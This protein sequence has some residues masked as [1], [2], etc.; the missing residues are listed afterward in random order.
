[1]RALVINPSFTLHTAVLDRYFHEVDRFELLT[2]DEEILLGEKIRAGDKSALDKLVKANLRFVISVAKK[3]Q[4][5]GMSLADLIAEGNIGLMT[6]AQRFDPSKGF[7]FISFAVWW[8]RQAIMH[9]ITQKQRMVRLPGNQVNTILSINQ[10]SMALEQMLERIPSVEQ[11]AEYTGLSSA[12]VLEGIGN[13]GWTLSLDKEPEREQGASLMELL[14][15]PN[16]LAP[17]QVLLDASV[18]EEL[19]E[20][21]EG[22]PERE[23]LILEHLYGLGGKVLLEAEDIARMLGLS[24]ERVRQLKYRAMKSLKERISPSLFQ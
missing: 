3:Y 16:A 18:S 1:M 2:F 4:H 13:S 24:K 9:A 19:L 10:A 17:D 15:C 22:L 7:K 21:L 20:A 11:L 14:S 23:K 8:I 5:S 12:K 6:A